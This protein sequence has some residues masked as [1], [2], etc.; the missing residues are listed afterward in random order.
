MRGERE[1]YISWTPL[2]PQ[3]WRWDRSG[4]RGGQLPALLIRARLDEREKFLHAE[5]A[6]LSHRKGRVHD[7]SRI[8][9]VLTIP[10]SQ[11]GRRGRN[12]ARLRAR[13]LPELLLQVA[14]MR[15]LS[16]DQRTACPNVRRPRSA[17]APRAL[18][19]PAL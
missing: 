4:G 8:W 18:S 16:G 2:G 12:R 19:P 5:L 15:L 3:R 6:I 7:G 1:R 13:C 9:S 10:R 11:G 17:P 14:P